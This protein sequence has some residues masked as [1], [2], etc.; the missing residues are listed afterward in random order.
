MPHLNKK[1]LLCLVWVTI[2]PV[3]LHGKAFS[4]PISL[5]DVEWQLVEMGGATVIPLPGGKRPTLFL[6]S[7]NKKAEGFSGCNNYFSHYQLN[8]SSLKFGPIGS[9]RRACPDAESIIEWNFF[10]TLEKTR[11]WGIKGNQLILFRDV[12]V[13]ARFMINKVK[14]STPDLASLTI[15]STVYRIS[16]VTLT[17]GQFRTPAAPD[18]TS[19]VVVKLT[20]IQAFGTLSGE[21]VG[22]VVVVTTLDGTGTF[23][24]LALLINNAQGWTNTDTVLLGDRVRVHS[25]AIESDHI[26]VAM[27]IHGSQDSMCCPTQEVRKRFIVQDDR[28]VMVS[29]RVH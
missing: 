11:A 7:A 22:T 15:R 24:E 8:G 13:L 10:A 3:V 25:V 23:Y 5:E 16:P 20:D 9:T 21:S 26:V 28:L 19:E 29:G 6:N 12:D 18:S 14:E 2:L 27:T 1:I 4:E 17:R